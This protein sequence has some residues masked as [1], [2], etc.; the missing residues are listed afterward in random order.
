MCYYKKMEENSIIIARTFYVKDRT[1]IIS[2]L[3]ADKYE[4]IVCPLTEHIFSTYIYVFG[5]NCDDEELSE[6]IEAEMKKELSE[7]RY[8]T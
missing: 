6:K 7:Y 2:K 8:M 1:I 5:S 4:E 3:I